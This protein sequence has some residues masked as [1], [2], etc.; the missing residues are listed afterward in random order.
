MQSLNNCIFK[1]V[2]NLLVNKNSTYYTVRTI[3]I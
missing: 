3:C 1:E 2:P